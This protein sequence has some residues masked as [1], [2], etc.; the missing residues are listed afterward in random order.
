M[1]RLCL[2]IFDVWTFLMSGHFLD[3]C[4]L[5]KF[6]SVG[7]QLQMMSGHFLDGCY[8]LRLCWAPC[9]CLDIFS[10]AIPVSSK[11]CLNIFSTET[12]CLDFV[13]SEKHK[14]IVTILPERI[15][16]ILFFDVGFRWVSRNALKHMWS[17]ALT[18]NSLHWSFHKDPQLFM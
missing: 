14:I 13:E 11:W 5:L 2:D 17:Y 15:L 6:C 8:L 1:S 18:S 7:L 9:C 4:Y 10:T 12:I 3:G 16:D